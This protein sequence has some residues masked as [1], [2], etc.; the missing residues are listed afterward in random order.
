[1]RRAS[2]FRDA[3]PR[4]SALMPSHELFDSLPDLLLLV[5][6]DGSPVAHAGGKSVAE[7][8]VRASGTGVLEP[9]WSEV[10]AALVRQLV[11][12]AIADRAAV[13]SQFSERDTHYEI[14]VHPQ[15]ADRALCVVRP[16]LRAADGDSAL[17]Q[18]GEHRKL[19]LDRRGFLRRFKESTALAT[20]RER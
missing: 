9:N 15:G 4:Y 2:T 16:S 3:R 5:R 18:T 1:A 13:E 19:Q 6:R 20:F 12:K 10:T 11:R 17:E 7:L 14:R 8:G